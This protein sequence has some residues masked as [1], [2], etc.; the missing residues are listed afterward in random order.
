MMREIVDYVIKVI[1]ELPVILSGALAVLLKIVDLI[2]KFTNLRELSG[3]GVKRK[4]KEFLDTLPFGDGQIRIIKVYLR[5]GVK[6]NKTFNDKGEPALI[7][8]I[9]SYQAKTV[10]CLLNYRAFIFRRT[11][12]VKIA[13]KTGTS[14]LAVAILVRSEN[15]A[16]M[17]IDRGAKEKKANCAY[18]IVAIEDGNSKEVSRLLML[19]DAADLEARNLEGD[20]PLMIAARFGRLNILKKLIEAGANVN[21]KNKKK[22]TPLILAA[23]FGQRKIVEVLLGQNE[24]NI[25]ARDR[26]GRTAT[27]AAR[28]SK[29]PDIEDLL[30]NHGGTINGSVNTELMEKVIKNN[31]VK[32]IKKIAADEQIFKIQTVEGKTL[33]TIASAENKEEKLK[34]LLENV[35]DRNLVNQK[36]DDGTN[37]LLAASAN[38][39][40]EIVRLLLENS[41]DP[42]IRDNSGNTPLHLASREGYIEIVKHLIRYNADVN[43]VG[44]VGETAL[45][46][47]AESGHYDIVRI[48]LNSEAKVDRGDFSGR[49][50]LFSGL[51]NKHEK[52]VRI[53]REAGAVGGEKE[54]LLI[55]AADEGKQ[56]EVIELVELGTDP[57]VKTGEGKT[58][59]GCA[60]KKGHVGVVTVLSEVEGANR[61]DVNTLDNSG[62]TPLMESVSAGYAEVVQ[63]LIHYNAEVDLRRLDGTTPLMEASQHGY[64]QI[65]AILINSNADVEAKRRDGWRPL[66]FAVKGKH[67]EVVQLLIKSHADVNAATNKGETPLMLAILV[68]DSKILKLLQRSGAKKDEQEENLYIAAR[69]G[70]F[71]QVKELIN[72]VAQIDTVTNSAKTP[73]MAAAERGHSN[74]V[75][76]LLDA[77]AN[78]NAKE[79]DGKTPLMLACDK[80]HVETAKA[81]IEFGAQVD[82]E[83]NSGRTALLLAILDQRTEI[84]DLL[85]EH[86]ATKGYNEAHLNLAA[87]EGNLE[88]V[89]KWIKLDVNI[90]QRGKGDQTVLLGACRYGS[91]EM[92]ELLIQHGADVNISVKDQDTPLTAAAMRGEISILKA[93]IKSNAKIDKRGSH[94]RTALICAAEE[95]HVKAVELLLDAGANINAK[96]TDGNTPLILAAREGREEVVKTLLKNR[97]EINVANKLRQTALIVTAE[98]NK[99]K[100]FHELIKG[101][102]DV[103]ARDHN[104][105]TTLILVS[106]KGHEDLVE[107]LIEKKADV[108]AR[109]NFGN[110]PLMGALLNRHKDVE[111]K[112]RIAKATEGEKEARLIL[113]AEE[114]QLDVVDRLIKEGANINAKIENCDSALIRAISTKHDEVAHLLIGSG[115]DVNLKGSSG[116]TALMEAASA[117]DSELVDA[118]IKKDAC[119]TVEAVNEKGQSAAMIAHL[120]EHNNIVG[121]IIGTCNALPP[122]GNVFITTSGH[123]Y[124]TGDCYFVKIE[125]NNI[126]LEDAVR[127]NLRPCTRC[128]TRQ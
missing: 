2:I 107:A 8:A 35:T 59:L 9:E 47:A 55:L 97:A 18:L 111:E 85:R 37:P 127:G 19:M 84:I 40:Q 48:L 68:G 103:D 50:A 124:H 33:L 45:I 24:I 116:R 102:A 16:K 41:A 46:L 29:Y 122:S 118:L 74:I 63:V 89:K 113:A 114:G 25:H 82:D 96:D 11:A 120:N 58:A 23:S 62:R 71:K 64:T 70:N 95:G 60:A 43:S 99:K 80:G 125:R 91:A 88:E 110:T 22:Q 28:E 105:S 5:A 123:C 39:H 126:K 13:S 121:L 20:T 49:T 67:L 17:L 72:N 115:A 93:L 87:K 76:L 10:E 6:P 61:T 119:K 51:V 65:A 34:I 42:N 112:L 21:V 56:H 38:G 86:Q 14:P 36:G 73:L 52:I 90:N 98:H 81:L 109:N 26:D 101:N 92:V 75:N 32:G 4:E 117:G 7:V 1:S 108:N 57:N 12:S 83:D 79:K 15:I 106:S 100:I 69:S 31:N 54:A 66:F 30:K 53:L 94:K 3:Q 27:D 77:D 78:P 44:P 128:I 104:N